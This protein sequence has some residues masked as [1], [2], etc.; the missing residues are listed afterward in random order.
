[1]AQ[2]TPADLQIA[3]VDPPAQASRGRLGSVSYVRFLR[4]FQH[5]YRSVSREH[6][7]VLVIVPYVDYFFYALPFLGSPF[8]ATPWI[9]ITMRA[10]F[11]HHRSAYVRRAGRSSMRSRR[12]LFR[13]ALRT[14]GLRTLLTI[15][16]TL[17]DWS[18]RNMPRR[19]ARAAVRICADPFPDTP[20]PRPAGRESGSA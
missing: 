10:T 15:D 5:M 6:G 14:P 11:H 18:A 3:F 7:V 17:R 16:P 2:T 19:M 9:G 12:S 4:Y 13:R 1:M 20:T 8:G